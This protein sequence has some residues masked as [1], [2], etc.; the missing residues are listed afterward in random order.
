MGALVV[1]TKSPPHETLLSEGSGWM[2]EEKRT[3]DGRNE[4]NL[5]LFILLLTI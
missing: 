2:A 5:L 3:K 4:Y 1:G